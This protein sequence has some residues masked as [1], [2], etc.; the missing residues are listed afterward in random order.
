MNSN[1]RRAGKARMDDPKLSS[2]EFQSIPAAPAGAIEP[3]H[4]QLDAIYRT[5]SRRV[6]ATLIRLLGGFDLA[7]EAL[8]EAFAAAV[9]QWPREGIPANPRAWL[10]ST[11]R[12]KA[13]DVMRRRARF[14]ASLEIAE[15]LEPRETMRTMPDRTRH[16]GRPAAPDL[17][18]LPSRPV[19]GRPGGADAA[20]GL[21]PDD[22]GDRPRLSHRRRPRSRSASFAPRP[23]SATRAFP[24]R[25]RRCR[26]AGS[27]GHGAARDLSGLQ[28]GLR[29]LV[30]RV[31]DAGRSVGRGDSPR[32]LAGRA[33][34]RARGAGPARADAAARVAS[35]G[36]HL[37]GRRAHAARRAGPRAAGIARR[38]PRARR[39]C[40][41]RSPRAGSARTPCRRRSRR[42]TP[43]RPTAAET[44]WAQIVGLY[45][46]LMRLEPSP[47]VELNRAVAVAM[48][49]GPAAGLALIDTILG[50]WR[51]RR[52]RAGPLGAGR[53]VPEAGE[54]RRRA[55]LLRSARSPSRGRSRSD[56]SSSDAWPSCGTDGAQ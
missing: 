25:C 41:A 31:A 46:V 15:R 47:V 35:C 52:L 32:A 10:V 20:R 40:S 6:L 48:R 29:G 7:E 36:A 17:H 39:W 34:A 22:R 50:A 56:A 44:D 8:H 43:R 19:A 5:D 55:R 37:A 27:A 24:T 54:D 18:L 9:E 3:V 4:E 13:I 1:A 45:D 33:A 14:D 51:P 30:G 26:A 42:C 2:D 49:D 53:S 21:R 11:G 28:R 12:F 23:R 16:R 38:S